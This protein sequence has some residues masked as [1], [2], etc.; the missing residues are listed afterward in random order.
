ASAPRTPCRE[1]LAVPLGVMPRVTPCVTLHVW[2]NLCRHV[3]DGAVARDMVRVVLDDIH[4]HVLAATVDRVARAV[5]LGIDNGPLAGADVVVALPVGVDG[6]VAV[7]DAD[8]VRT[9]VGVDRVV[10]GA[11][12]DV[13]GSVVAPDGVGATAGA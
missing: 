11:E 1:R 5:V 7:A 6:V 2:R 9:A 13:V 10:P 8:V 3:L 4:G 12:V